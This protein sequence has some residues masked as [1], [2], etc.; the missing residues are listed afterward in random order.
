MLGNIKSVFLTRKKLSPNIYEFKFLLKEPPFINFLPGQYLIILFEKEGETKRKFYSISS[1]RS[2]KN[3]IE[4]IVKVIESGVGS[5]Y[6]MNLN[7]GDDVMLQGPAGL[8]VLKESK[9][10]K[11][12][13]AT[14]TGIAPI[15]S[16]IK[17]HLKGSQN[18]FVLFWGLRKN[19]DMYYLDFLRDTAQKYNN[20]SYGVFLSR[21]EPRKSDNSSIFHGRVNI[22][23]EKLLNE[24]EI[25]KRNLEFYVSGD[26]YI[27]DSLREYLL[28]NGISAEDIKL[29]KFI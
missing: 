12:F 16:M 29:E 10:H 2:E 15:F 18:R 6:L 20:F 3:Q 27:V 14:G 11:I 23:I 4:F 7:E 17:T 28:T 25:D 8:F 22:G 24:P 26:R 19:E 5:E 21:E 1:S 13:I 9:K